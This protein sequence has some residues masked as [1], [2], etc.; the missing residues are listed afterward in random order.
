M[1]EL[2][3]IL[4]YQKS[5]FEALTKKL[6]SV[7]KAYGVDIANW[8]KTHN[9]YHAVLQNWKASNDE[10][11]YHHSR[12][13]LLQQDENARKVLGLDKGQSAA[14]KV[15]ELLR[16]HMVDKKVFAVR[17]ATLR[18]RLSTGKLIQTTRFLGFRSQMSMLK[19]VHPAVV[20]MIATYLESQKW[21]IG[22]EQWF[23]HLSAVDLQDTCPVVWTANA[24][25][26]KILVDKK[27]M[28]NAEPVI[29]NPATAC[30]VVLQA[31]SKGAE[32]A[33][34]M[35]SV[36]RLLSQQMIPASHQIRIAEGS[37]Q[38]GSLLW[39][40]N[41]GQSSGHIGLV[42]G[43]NMPVS[44]LFA[45]L[46]RAGCAD[47]FEPYLTGQHLSL[48]AESWR[49]LV[50]KLYSGFVRLD[51]AGSKLCSLNLLD[52]AKNTYYKRQY[53]SHTNIHFRQAINNSWLGG[54]LVDPSF[55]EK[56]CNNLML[57][58]GASLI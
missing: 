47:A 38:L 14:V 56:I 54:Y 4:G 13:L 2:V 16:T 12:E 48:N 43:L 36:N 49:H 50:D 33:L 35:S 41:L 34:Y 25:Q 40:F 58:S 22:H 8:H 55:V 21:R 11:A 20:A 23:R 53:G 27:L 6:E 44:T 42:E 37:D 57:G 29:Y 26:T 17:S 46:S 32:L 52:V 7:T 15:S 24:E 28:I 18:K 9:S 1:L 30:F 5:E 51:D 31:A 45:R 3:N 10:Q 19:S 39:R